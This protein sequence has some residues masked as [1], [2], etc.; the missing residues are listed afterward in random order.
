M[1]AVGFILGL[2]IVVMAPALA[3]AQG[4]TPQTPQ[5]APMGPTL[6][7][8]PAAAPQIAPRGPT[9]M[10]TVPPTFNVQPSPQTV[11]DI[12]SPLPSSQ[13]NTI[14]RAFS[15]RVIVERKLPE[16]NTSNRT[17]SQKVIMRTKK[18]FA[19]IRSNPFVKLSTSF[20]RIIAQKYAESCIF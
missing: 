8:P 3:P 12:A 11:L 20:S 4:R 14:S 17:S 15:D 16:E 19:D 9:Q 6:M 1:K 13:Q 18:S 7:L 10:R 5:I 2:S